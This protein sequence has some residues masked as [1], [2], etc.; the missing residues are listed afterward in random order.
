[1]VLSEPINVLVEVAVTVTSGEENGGEDD[2]LED[3]ELESVVEGD[4]DGDE[5]DDDDEEEKMCRTRNYDPIANPLEP[6]SERKFKTEKT[7]YGVL[8]VG[9][10]LI[11]DWSTLRDSGNGEAAG[12]RSGG[13]AE[14]R[15]RGVE[16]YL[17][18]LQD[19][20]SSLLWSKSFF[21]PPG[22]VHLSFAPLSGG[23]SML[24]SSAGS[25]KT[26]TG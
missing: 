10:G 1:M 6:T 20:M 16:V 4:K 5:E 21:R 18:P 13:G 19:H 12:E 8:D 11:H 22:F 14:L 17:R 25:T 9:L 26:S 24:T 3:K 23:S 2:V 7:T 15:D